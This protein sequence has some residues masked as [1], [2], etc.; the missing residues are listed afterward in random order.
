LPRPQFFQPT[1]PTPVTTG[2]LAAGASKREPTSINYHEMRVRHRDTP[3]AN[4]LKGTPYV[5]FFMPADQA[6]P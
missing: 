6:N 3:E 4:P 1:K 5:Q 2:Q